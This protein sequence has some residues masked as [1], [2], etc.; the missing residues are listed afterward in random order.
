[1]QGFCL[2]FSRPLFSSCAP[3]KPEPAAR[4]ASDLLLLQGYV[5]PLPLVFS[6]SILLGKGLERHLHP[7]CL[8]PTLLCLGSPCLEAGD[9]GG[10]RLCVCAHVRC[11]SE[12]LRPAPPNPVP[13]RPSG[14]GASEEANPE[15][16]NFLCCRFSCPRKQSVGGVEGAERFRDPAS[17]ARGVGRGDPATVA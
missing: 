12:S 15:L 9:R 3:P 2:L 10:H 14:L 5:T 6:F 16:H 11:F 13:T 8:V 4:A 17:R 7:S 1:M